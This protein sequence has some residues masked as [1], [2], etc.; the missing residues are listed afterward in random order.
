LKQKVV[1]DVKFFARMILEVEMDEW[2][3]VVWCGVVWSSVWRNMLMLG[4]KARSSGLVNN[5]GSGKVSLY[6][7]H[8]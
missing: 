5:K 1:A 4:T 8:F 6:S 2:G 7:H 3:G